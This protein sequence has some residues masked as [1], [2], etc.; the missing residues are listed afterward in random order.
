MPTITVGGRDTKQ[1]AFTSIVASTFD[2]EVRTTNVSR[3]GNHWDEI[4]TGPENAAVAVKDI[5][6]LGNHNCYVALLDGHR[7]TG[8]ILPDDCK[9]Y[10]ELTNEGLCWSLYRSGY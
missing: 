6:N 2:V 3:S 7:V 1:G 4:A 5:S 9:C 8:L 10:C